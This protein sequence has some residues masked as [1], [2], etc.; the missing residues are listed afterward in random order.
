MTE[1]IDATG[2]SCPQPVIL[3]RNIMKKGVTDFE[4]IVDSEVAKENVI[5][6]VA[7]NNLNADISSNGDTFTIK[8]CKR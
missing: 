1:R 3:V 5:R 2:L 7:K 8:V 4:V 6:S